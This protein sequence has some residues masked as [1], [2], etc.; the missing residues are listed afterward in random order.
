MTITMAKSKTAPKSL[1]LRPAGHTTEHTELPS[2]E[3]GSG[4]SPERFHDFVE[5]ETPNFDPYRAA[6]FSQ[7]ALKPLVTL[8]TFNL[9]GQEAALGSWV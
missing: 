4:R 5:V 8:S 6:F 2:W 7:G 9:G 3:S 1:G